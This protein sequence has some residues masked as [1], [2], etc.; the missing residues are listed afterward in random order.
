MNKQS[1]GHKKS[2]SGIIDQSKQREYVT[3]WEIAC[4]KILA[5]WN[6][7]RSLI[8]SNSGSRE[9]ELHHKLNQTFCKTFSNDVSNACIYFTQK[10]NRYIML[11]SKFYNIANKEIFPHTVTQKLL[12]YYTHGTEHYENFYFVA[13]LNKSLD[14]IKKSNFPKV[15]GNGVT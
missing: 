12:N 15:V 8:D 13:K 11:E 14:T 9:T 3:K 4:H 2:I 1:T 5:I 7:F 10:G 6:K